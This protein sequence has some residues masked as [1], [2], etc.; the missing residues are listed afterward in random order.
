MIKANQPEIRLAIAQWVGPIEARAPDAVQVNKGHGRLE[1]REVW[2]G[3]CGPLSTYLHQRFGWPGAQWCGWIRRKR[4]P[5]AGTSWQVS[6]QIWVAGAAF[7]LRLEAQLAAAWLRG[8]WAIENG[9]FRIRDVTYDEDRL[10]GRAI[11]VGLS[12]IRN[13]AIN[14]IRFLGYDFIPDGHRAIAA[15]PHSG[16]HLLN[17]SLIL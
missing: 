13:V 5:A 3:A 9:V 10:H 7:E 14:I 15:M 4:K 8:H 17:Q 12:S 11:G 1:R 2:L 16:L 6:E